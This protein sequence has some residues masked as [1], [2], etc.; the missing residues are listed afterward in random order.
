MNYWVWVMPSGTCA[1]RI[2]EGREPASKLKMKAC[3]ETFYNMGNVWLCVGQIGVTL[4]CK[5][6]LV[7]HCSIIITA[8]MSYIAVLF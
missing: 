2:I 6:L 7:S 3:M 4:F 8:A 1:W 5:T